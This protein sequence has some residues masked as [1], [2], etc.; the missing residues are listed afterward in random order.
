[1]K[2]PRKVG[3]VILLGS[4][5]GLAIFLYLIMR[6]GVGDIAQAFAKAGWGL[7]LVLLAHCLNRLCDALSW[8]ALVPAENR[9]PIWRFVLY[10][11]VGDSVSSLLPVAQVG[12]EV[13]RVRFLSKATGADG[14]PVPLKVATS[15]VLVGMTVSLATQI[16][17]LLAGLAVLVV[18]T[19]QHGLTIPIL[20]A[21]GISLLCAGGFYAVQRTGI[22]KFACRI[23]SHVAAKSDWEGLAS[24]G[25]ELDQDIRECYSRRSAILASALWHMA[26]WMSGA[27]EVWAAL[28]ALHLPASFTDAFILESLNQGIRS[29]AFLVPGALGFQ[30]G[31]YVGIGKVLGIAAADALALSLLRRARELVFG[32]PGVIA[33]Q[34]LEGHRFWFRRPLPRLAP[35]PAS[36]KPS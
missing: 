16:L 20:L 21:A 28:W 6:Q 30:E 17:F 27:L 1:M 29:A 11:W 35:E 2:I 15:S 5:L 4:L 36:D 34:W 33:W 32:I 14:R 3:T 12:G 26:T 25:A 23:I 13:L 7:T 31:G 24:R 8:R 10:H 19:G 22:F 18:V 9:P